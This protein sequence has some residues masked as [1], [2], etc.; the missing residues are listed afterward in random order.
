MDFKHKG[1]FALKRSKGGMKGW[2][3]RGGREMDE[4]DEKPGMWLGKG[5]EAAAI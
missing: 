1:V 5:K 2:M 4:E 3:K